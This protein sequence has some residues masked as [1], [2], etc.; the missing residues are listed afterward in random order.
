MYCRYAV[1][2]NALLL[3]FSGSAIMSALL[4]N[5]NAMT[6]RLRTRRLKSSS[7][8][9]QLVLPQHTR[10]ISLSSIR[11]MLQTHHSGQSTP[12]LTDESSSQIKSHFLAR[13]TLPSPRS[14]QARPSIARSFLVSVARITYKKKKTRKKH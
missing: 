9:R 14:S 7:W 6:S 10:S 13:L 4:R 12:G 5:A 1:L 8:L 3:L 11:Q 2:R